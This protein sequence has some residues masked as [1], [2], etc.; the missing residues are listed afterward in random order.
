MLMAMAPMHKDMH[1]WASSK[2]QEWQDRRQ[3]SAMPNHEIAA[4]ESGKTQH[5]PATIGPEAVE[6][7]HP[8]S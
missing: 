7:D 3:M 2:H 1:E 5:Q 4:Q 6:H 8:P